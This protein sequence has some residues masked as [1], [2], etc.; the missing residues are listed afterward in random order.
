MPTTYSMVSLVVAEKAEVH[1]ALTAAIKG[2][3][4]L[5]DRR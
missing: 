2:R 4:I 1:A 3:A 5:T